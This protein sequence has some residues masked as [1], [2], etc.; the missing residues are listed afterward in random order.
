[1]IHCWES[2]HD[3]DVEEPETMARLDGC[4]TCEV[5]EIRHAA[6]PH[7]RRGLLAELAAALPQLV[8]QPDATRSLETNVG[9]R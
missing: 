5:R 2:Y 8:T 9:T 1:V 7:L 6:M 3:E 4:L